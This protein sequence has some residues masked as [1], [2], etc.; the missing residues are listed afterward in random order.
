MKKVLLSLMLVT[1]MLFSGLVFAEDEVIELYVGESIPLDTKVVSGEIIKDESDIVW[2]Y[3]KDGICSISS[4]DI[5]TG[6]KAGLVTVTG[7]LNKGGTI[8]E[9]QFE[10]LVKNTVKSVEVATPDQDL[11]VGESFTV[12]YNLIPVDLLPV[13]MNKGVKFKSTDTDVL[14]VTSSGNVTIVGIGDAYVQVES[15]E[16]GKKAYV[17]VNVDPTVGKI[18]INEKAETI[19]VGEETQM[20]VAYT[21]LEGKTIFL[22]ESTWESLAKDYLT[23]DKEG[24]IKGVKAGK[25][26]LRAISKDN[27][28]TSSVSVK[29]ITGVEKVYLTDKTIELKEDYKTHQLT[30]VIVPV[31]GLDEVFEDGV[32]WSSSNTSVCSVSSSGKLTAK[33]TGTATITVTTKD[34]EKKAYATV[35]VSLPIEVDRT[36][37]IKDVEFLPMDQNVKVGQ[38]ILLEVK[39]SPENADASKVS[40]NVASSGFGKIVKEDGL[41]YFYA[42][43][44]GACVIEAKADGNKYD[45]HI[46]FGKSMLSDYDIDEDSFE[47]YR[48][49]NAIYIGQKV[50][51][52][53]DF[54][55]VDG[56]YPLLDDI[57][58]TSSDTKRAK[59]VDDNWIEGVSLGTVTLKGVTADNNLED[60]VTVN[61]ISNIKEIVA[62]KSARIGVDMA[63]T[64][65]V[66]FV[67]ID[68]PL[69]DLDE[70]LATDYEMTM[71][72]VRISSEFV[73][74]EIEYT[75]KRIE[76]L[77]KLIDDK[78]G[79]LNAHLQE[80]QK[81]HQRKFDYES[82]YK[83]KSGDFCDVTFLGRDLMDRS[84]KDL[85]IAKISKNTLTAKIVSEILLELVSEDPDIKTE[86]EVT[87]ED[88]MSSIVIFDENGEI[89]TASVEHILNHYTDDILFQNNPSSWAVDF[90]TLSNSKGLL[91]D[92]VIDNYQANIT[93]EE[94]MELVMNYYN[95][96]LDFPD[97]DVTSDVFTDTNNQQVLKAYE[98]G[99]I[100]GRGPGIF[101]PNDKV[102]REEMCVIIDKSLKVMD[103]TL[104]LKKTYRN[105]EDASLISSWA[106]DA[107]DKMANDHDI[108]AGVGG[109]MFSPKGNATKEQAIIMI[110]KVFDRLN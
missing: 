62:E 99:I 35:K 28:R 40:F 76:E 88:N 14:T 44:G 45:E 85:E 33:K 48:G 11:R 30:A 34:G 39:V 24:K 93:R 101:A 42:L 66:H 55:V 13:P 52:E 51:I 9:V 75:E 32:S 5:V 46:F 96:V 81:A 109:N 15:T 102:T 41:Y 106:K 108:I 1:V 12:A 53:P 54:D 43:K 49:G 50:E 90:I 23:V 79:D 36:V 63:Y 107:V 22:K 2:T 37:D 19:Y 71:K 78:S 64:P 61:V 74:K 92:E 94:F 70:V 68:E 86:I 84:Y 89:I 98:L 100:S 27:E 17:K 31:D 77:N 67:A 104:A 25:A 8:L 95:V 57:K 87:V 97:V 83:K 29:I 60:T 21:P 103:R 20:S 18:S 26:S 3:S 58:Y 72:E 6:K 73:E 47:E 38:K 65:N 80:L 10:V 7:N 82:V 110:Y 59:I 56:S 105:F 91:V 69:Y 16:A 4:S